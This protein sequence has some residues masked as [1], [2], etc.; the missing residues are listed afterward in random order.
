VASERY[1]E[2]ASAVAPEFVSDS[3]FRIAYSQR[4]IILFPRMRA[5]KLLKNQI[6][7]DEL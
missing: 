7:N 1:V 3:G 4:H 5:R 2:Y 6:E